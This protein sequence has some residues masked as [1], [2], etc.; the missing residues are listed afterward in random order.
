MKSMLTFTIVLSSLSLLA[1]TEKGGFMIGGGGT[2]SRTTNYGSAA[3]SGTTSTN[4][5]ISPSAGYFVI[6]NLAV[7]TSLSY[8][9]NKNHFDNGSQNV[10]GSGYGFGAG[11]FVRYYVPAGPVYVISELAYGWSRTHSQSEVNSPPTVAQY[12]NTTTTTKFQ[13]GGWRCILPEPKRK[14]GYA[15]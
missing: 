10:V 12:E 11:P 3:T 5:G 4:F 9:H 2:L 15:H 1:Q 14:P 7:G 6:K 8:S 13:A